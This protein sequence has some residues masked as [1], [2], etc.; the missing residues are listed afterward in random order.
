MLILSLQ[1]VSLAHKSHKH[2]RGFFSPSSSIKENMPHSVFGKKPR[3]VKEKEPRT[4][5]HLGP[6]VSFSNWQTLN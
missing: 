1:A 6:K 5:A 3:Q 4:Q 2:S